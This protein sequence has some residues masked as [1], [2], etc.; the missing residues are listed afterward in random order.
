[1]LGIEC[2]KKEQKKK[3]NTVLLQFVANAISLC[4]TYT[5]PEA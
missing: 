4:S 1:M 5:V 2:Q 3:K